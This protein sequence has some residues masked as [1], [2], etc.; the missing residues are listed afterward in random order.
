MIFVCLI[1]DVASPMLPLFFIVPDVLS[2]CNILYMPVA[3]SIPNLIKRTV[4][5]LE[6]KHAPNTL[7]EAG[8][9]VPGEMWVS[10]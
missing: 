6:D 1:S 9:Q 4:E 8:I 7:D 2:T 3:T 10:I 5:A